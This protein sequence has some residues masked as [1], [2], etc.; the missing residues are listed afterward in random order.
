MKHMQ[1]HPSG[2]V[3]V[4]DGLSVGCSLQLASQNPTG[5]AQS[6]FQPCIV[7]SLT[8][9]STPPLAALPTSPTLPPLLHAHPSLIT[10]PCPP[11][12]PTPWSARPRPPPPPLLATPPCTPAIQLLW[13]PPSFRHHRL[14]RRSTATQT[15]LISAPP[16]LKQPRSPVSTP[17]LHTPDH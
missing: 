5:Q 13:P 11:P 17:P 2:F 6:S 4:A 16:G 9:Y 7:T 15:L 12:L 3:Q 8:L 1:H 10:L 14:A